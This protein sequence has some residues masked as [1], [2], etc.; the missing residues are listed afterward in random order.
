MSSYLQP[1]DDGGAS[2]PIIETT[3]PPLSSEASQKVTGSERIPPHLSNNRSANAIDD[4]GHLV[5]HLN[6]RGAV[7]GIAD[8][9]ARGSLSGVEMKRVLMAQIVQVQ[10]EFFQGRSS[11]FVEFLID[12]NI[13]TSL[14]QVGLLHSQVQSL[15][16]TSVETEDLPQ[17]V[18]ESLSTT[19]EFAKLRKIQRGKIDGELRM[20]NFEFGQTA[21]S[22][23]CKLSVE[24]RAVA[25]SVPE[26]AM[27]LGEEVDPSKTK[28]HK[29]ISPIPLPRFMSK[30]NKNMKQ[31]PLFT[32]KLSKRKGDLYMVYHSLKGMLAEIEKHFNKYK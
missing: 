30:M 21:M 28:N 12:I 2:V 24:E 18:I 29:V 13:K 7:E 26:E 20:S 10:P 23:S 6:K 27:E 3:V 14:K 16:L 15:R 1:S 25:L 31:R 22:L 17:Q 8:V 32:T 4:H 11:K 19:L 5:M 9:S